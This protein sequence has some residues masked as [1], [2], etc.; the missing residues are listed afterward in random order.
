MD[1]GDPSEN[2]GAYEWRKPIHT[3]RQT[4]AS[5]SLCL[6]STARARGESTKARHQPLSTHRTPES[7]KLRLKEAPSSPPRLNRTE[8]RSLSHSLEEKDA[9][10]EPG[11]LSRL[12][13]RPLAQV[14]ISWLLSSSPTSGSGLTA[15]SLEPASDSVSPSLSAPSL[16]TRAL[17]LSQN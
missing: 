11:W 16:L 9:P 4:L 1:T 6:A 14:M 10:G 2:Q 12:V 15:R 17:S 7:S 5:S 3:G 8:E 13:V